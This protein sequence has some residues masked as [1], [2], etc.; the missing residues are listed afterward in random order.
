MVFWRL[1]DGVVT[2]LPRENRVQ[3]ASFCTAWM[4]A[5]VACKAALVAQRRSSH[6]AAIDGK[7][8]FNRSV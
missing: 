7:L 6:T 8:A 2:I 1:G 4:G 3:H 5:E